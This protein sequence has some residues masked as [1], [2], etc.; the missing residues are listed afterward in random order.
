MPSLQRKNILYDAH[1][2]D[3]Y[4]R[5]VNSLKLKRSRY[6]YRDLGVDGAVQPD[7]KVTVYDLFVLW[8]IR[9]ANTPIPVGGDML[10]RNAAHRGPVFL[11]W[12]RLMLVMLEA[13]IQ[14]AINESTFRLPYWDWSADGDSGNPAGAQIW[15]NAYMG[16]QG[17]PVREG[18]FAFTGGANS[19]WIR[20]EELEGRAVYTNRGLKRA[21]LNDPRVPWR[22]PTS[23]EVKSALEFAPPADR[24]DAKPEDRYDVLDFSAV[25]DGFRGRLEGFTPATVNSRPWLHN[26]VHAWVGGDMLPMSSP[27]D[28]VFFLHHCNVDRLW[29]SWMSHYGRIYSPDGTA[30]DTYNGERTDDGLFGPPP[31]DE[32]LLR[33]T[34]VLDMR[35]L[36]TYDKLV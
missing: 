2:R 18:P 4:I 27:N 10:H 25:S 1:A 14:V 3:A 22:L 20:I 28:P 8:H 5:G 30:S 26:Q 24:P 19:F 23:A 36:Y 9:A 11:P 29:E 15:T 7:Q 16:P 35:S 13:Q 34:D 31:W 21:F 6:T 33:I 12:H 17:D 32:R